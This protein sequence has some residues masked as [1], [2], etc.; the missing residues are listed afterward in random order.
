MNLTPGNYIMACFFP[1]AEG[2]PHVALGMAKP[3]TVTAATRPFAAGPAPEL[4]IDLAD[5]RFDISAPISAGPQTF[6]V[7]NKGPQDHEAFLVLLAPGYTANDF[8]G[9]FQAIAAGGAAPSALILL[10][11]TVR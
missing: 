10:R 7:V 4:T 1:N 3:L 5:F 11:A 2:V 8:V 9:A 6:R